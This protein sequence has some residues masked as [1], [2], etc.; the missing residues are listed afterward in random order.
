[1]RRFKYVA[2]IAVCT[3]AMYA[4]L[5][6]AGRQLVFT[7]LQVPGAVLTNAQGINA[8][9]DVV[10]I[11]TDSAGLQHGFLWSRGEFAS[12]DVPGARVTAARGIGPNGEIVGTYQ[13]VGE[14]GGIPAHGFLLTTQGEFLPMDFPGHANTI[15]QRI[16]ADGTVLGCYHDADLMGSM[17]GMMISPD[18][19][20]ELPEGMSM[21]NGATPDGTLIVG[22]YTDMDGRT[23]GYRYEGGTLTPLEV[24]G[25]TTTAAWDINPAGM[26][27]GVFSDAAGAHGFT[28]DGVQF[29][30]INVP[31]ATA[32]RVFGIN[33]GGDI[34]G[35]YVQG[36]VTRGF[37]G[38]WT[39]AD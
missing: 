5:A 35:N 15:P 34:V 31:G 12:I 22:L 4:S 14:S 32:T 13:R 1:M 36:G 30:H 20:A 7:T 26:V 33:A 11:Y 18:G 39:S 21:H 2:A 25:S 19:V 24:P 6:G 28:F 29:T 38:R 17:H 23:N 37:I 16:L 10:G 8:R 9:G 3:G 27:V